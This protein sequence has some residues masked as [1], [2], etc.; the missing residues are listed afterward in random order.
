MVGHFFSVQNKNLRVKKDQRLITD[1]LI[2]ECLH[3][4]GPE[5]NFAFDVWKFLE[6]F[7]LVLRLFQVRLYIYIQIRTILPCCF[8]FN[9]MVIVKCYLT[10]HS[11]ANWSSQLEPSIVREQLLS[12]L[13]NCR[14]YINSL[15]IWTP[16]FVPFQPIHWSLLCFF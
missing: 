14:T 7:C 10:Q 9:W 8:C 2:Y 6:L 1:F 3:L 12:F 15:L 11:I 5:V 16:A 4:T 13:D